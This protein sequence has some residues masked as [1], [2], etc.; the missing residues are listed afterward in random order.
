[1]ISGL[2]SELIEG[3]DAAC[4]GADGQGEVIGALPGHEGHTLDAL[5]QDGGIDGIGLGAGLHGLGEAFGGLG[6]DDHDRESGVIQGEGQIE[7]ILAGGLQADAAHLCLAQ[8][9]DEGCV[10]RGV[11]LNSR[12]F[13]RP[14]SRLM[15]KVTVWSLTSIPATIMFW[16]SNVITIS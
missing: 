13:P 6:V 3:R 1:L 4:A 5:G 15:V 14:L 9:V 7:V 8:A 10:P 11:F 12:A 16:F 2:G